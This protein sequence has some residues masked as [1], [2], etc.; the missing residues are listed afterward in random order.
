MLVTAPPI[1]TRASG[2]TAPSSECK[3]RGNRAMRLL[4]HLRRYRL[5]E[6]ESL[7]VTH[8]AHVHAEL[9][10]DLISVSECELRAAAAGIEDDE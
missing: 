5:I 10:V 7:G 9:A 1:P 2:G 8:S 4:Q 3:I 6:P